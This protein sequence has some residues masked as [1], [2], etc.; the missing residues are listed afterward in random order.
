MARDRGL[1]L[2]GLVALFVIQPLLQPGLPATADTPIHFYR[3]LEFAHSWGPGVVY[4]RWAPHLAYGYGYPLWDF[5]P[6]LPYLIPLALRA[7]GFSLETGF[8]GLLAL[9]AMGYALGAYLLARQSLGAKPALVAAAVF[10]LSPFALREA[11]LYGGNYPQYLAIALYPWVL[12]GLERIHRRP[13]AGN[14]ALTAALYGAVMLS[15]LFHALLITPVAAAYAAVLWLPRRRL[16]PLLLSAAAMTLGLLGTAFFWLPAFI[17]RAFTRATSDVYLAVSPLF[18]RFL[19]WGELL[20]LPQP[21][22]GRA[23]NPWVPFSLGAATLALAAIGAATWLQTAR[24]RSPLFRRGLFFALLLATSVF[25]VLPASAPVWKAVPLLGVAEFPWRLL[26]LANLSLAF[27]AAMGVRRFGGRLETPAAAVA[28]L[29]V[30]LASMVYLYPP[31]P[32][33][34]YGESLP[35]LTAYELATRTIGTTT[36][37]E[38]L[39]RAVT[40]IPTT[41]PLADALAQGRPIEQMRVESPEGLT[42]C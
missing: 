35:D 17:E 15:H 39:P 11:L 8:K 13:T 12:W 1:L 18:T 16:R 3:A 41:S 5:A 34:R 10:A 32:F 33:L 9:S 28:V 25:M 38:Y 2:A 14:V 22:D 6:P 7:M 23:A 31:R 30:L 40:T 36:L 4:P 42:K 21:L 20:A 26:G 19:N 27:L 37:G 29:A 24:P